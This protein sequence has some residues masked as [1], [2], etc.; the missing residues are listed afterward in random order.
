MKKILL[1]EDD[2]FL[3]DI[4]TTKL[5]SEGYEVFSATDGRQALDL[6][7]EE[8]FDLILLDIILPKIDGWEV[9][10]K[11]RESGKNKETKVIV[12][13]N[14]EEI[15]KKEYEDLSVEACLIKANYTPQETVEEMK[16]VL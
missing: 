2:R 7:D 6:L 14:S 3:I 16:K 5:E 13:S 8:H 11:M 4:Y 1:V 12:I 15:V 9:L 10:K